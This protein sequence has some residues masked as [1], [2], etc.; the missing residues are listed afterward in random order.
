LPHEASSFENILNPLDFRRSRAES[1]FNSHQR[2][3]LSYNWE[4]PIP[5]HSGLPGKLAN[6]WAISGITTFQSGFPIR[7]TSSSDLELENSFDFELPG[8]PDIVKPFPHH[9]PARAWSFLFR[10]PRSSRIRPSALSR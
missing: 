10:I 9:G 2:F 1:L 5:K 7:I 4:L 8:E 6:G 3:V